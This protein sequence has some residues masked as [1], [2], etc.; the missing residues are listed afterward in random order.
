MKR[1]MTTRAER[2]HL[3]NFKKLFTSSISVNN[4]FMMNFQIV[5]MTFNL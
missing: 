3:V 5:F 1:C 2:L 4:Y